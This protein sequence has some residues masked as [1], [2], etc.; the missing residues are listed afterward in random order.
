MGKRCSMI[1]EKW[2]LGALLRKGELVPSVLREVSPDNF[3]DPLYKE[4]ARWLS[5]LGEEELSQAVTLAG[6]FGDTA[7]QDALAEILMNVPIREGTEEQM[8]WDCVRKI[9]RYRK[10]MEKKELLQQLEKNEREGGDTEQ[11]QRRVD[12]KVRKIHLLKEDHTAL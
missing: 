5:G 12:E 6:G 10:E 7:V 1:E 3:R 9:Q 4:I 8:A 2:L 11:L